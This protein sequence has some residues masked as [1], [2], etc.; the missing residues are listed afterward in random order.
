MKV[1]EEE[2]A[3]GSKPDE[4]WGSPWDWGRF[5][6]A[7]ERLVTNSK[8]AEEFEAKY[9]DASAQVVLWKSNSTP[10][11]YLDGYGNLVA[12]LNHLKFAE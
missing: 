6:R 5:F 8:C 9:R 12:N 4:G 7:E 1:E 3:A 2:E 10:R 11:L